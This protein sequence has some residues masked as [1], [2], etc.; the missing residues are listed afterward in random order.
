[1]ADL[2]AFLNLKL[3]R[4]V[5]LVFSLVTNGYIV[6][7]IEGKIYT[8][9]SKFVCVPGLSCYSCPGALGSC[10]I[11][12]LQ[13]ILSSRNFNFSFYIVG[14]LIITGV[15]LGRLV[16]GWLCPFGF[17][18]D[19]LYKIP[20]SKKLKTLPGHMILR[21]LK[22]VI[23][24]LFVI[25]LP[26]F[27]IDV[28]G[29]GQ[30]WFCE[31]ICPAGTLMAGIPLATTNEGIR[32]SLGWLFAWK[33]FLLIATIILS[34]IVFRPFCQYICPLGAIYGLFNPISLY[35]FNINKEKCTQCGAC[36]TSC[37]LNIS[38]F[39]KP[40]DPECIRC[41]DCKKACPHKAID[42]GFTIKK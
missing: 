39:E 11:G 26:I 34:I 32:D 27:I 14:F 22:Y 18:Q 13:A 16:C 41:G 3:Q 8:G 31:F 28:I 4:L 36:Q 7:F 19:L 38:V 25:I 37:K 5:Q 40:N 20:F 17:F 9:K 1:M 21:F 42:S 23:L 33:F 10:P 35:N 12:S 30:P 15:F 2:F 6:G 24:I 29:Q